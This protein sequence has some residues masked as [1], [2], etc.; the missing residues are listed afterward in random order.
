M[1]KNIFLFLCTLP[2]F[3]RAQHMSMP[4]YSYTPKPDYSFQNFMAM[5]AM[6]HNYRVYG[7]VSQ[8]HKFK[9]LMKDSSTLEVVARIDADSL[10]RY[11]VYTDHSVK[12]SDSGRIKKIYPSQT[13]AIS[14][15]DRPDVYEYTG[16]PADS[17]WLFP[18]IKGSLTAYAALAE[19]VIDEAFLLYI[20][21]GAGPLTRLTGDNLEANIKGDEKAGRL[22]KKKKY[23][24]AIIKFNESENQRA[25][26]AVTTGS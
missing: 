22:L 11:L 17:C 26:P 7:T 4:N 19:D 21:K 3:A 10:T 24:R 5:N 12:R 20:Q 2:L 8:K 25:A 15:I 14:R 18:A 1:F 23:S 13:L 9:V 16:I 6:F